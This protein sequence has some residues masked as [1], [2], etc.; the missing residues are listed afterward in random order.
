MPDTLITTESGTRQPFTFLSDVKSQSHFTGEETE[1]LARGFTAQNIAV[2]ITSAHCDKNSPPESLGSGYLSSVCFGLFMPRLVGGAPS[3]DTCGRGSSSQADTIARIRGAQ[4]LPRP[5]SNS[6]FSASQTLLPK[7][8]EA[9]KT[10]QLASKHGCQ[11]SHET[12]PQQSILPAKCAREMQA[13]N[14]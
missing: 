2:L 9:F 7:G 1:A 13:Q 4:N 11:L 10:V 8:S 5:K 14:L 6:D 12:F 3:V